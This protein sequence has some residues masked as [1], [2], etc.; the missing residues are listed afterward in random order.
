MRTDT[1]KRT[2]DLDG[3]KGQEAFFILIRTSRFYCW[4]GRVMIQPSL[5][6][7]AFHPATEIQRVLFELAYLLPPKPHLCFSF[8]VYPDLGLPQSHPPLGS[9]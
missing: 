1:E 2:A 6:Y 7:L 4:T 3:Q 5:T 9:G 8:Y